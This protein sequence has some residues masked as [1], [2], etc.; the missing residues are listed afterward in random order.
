[1]NSDRPIV[2]Q[3]RGQWYTDGALPTPDPAAVIL[4]APTREYPAAISGHLREFGLPCQVW[5]DKNGLGAATATYSAIVSAASQYPDR[6]ILF[7]EDDISFHPRFGAIV[8]AT[9][10]PWNVGVV[11]F[12]DMREMPTG[13]PDGLYTL[14]ALGCD[15][16]GWWGNQCILIHR[17][18]AQWLITRSFFEAHIEESRGVRAHRAAYEDGG[19]NCS[20]IRLSLL[21][22]Q[23]PIR[24]R[25]AVHVPSLALHIGQRSICFPDRS[26]TLGERETRNY[27]SEDWSPR[28]NSSS[29]IARGKGDVR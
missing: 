21:V 14:S 15:G 4:Q 16:R 10:I 26:P 3:E 6:H 1:M 24:R 9:Q 5:H 12:C 22:D 25:Y 20:D 13:S 28:A 17:D 2:N 23:H 7:C 29:V 19:K 27:A 8:R 18:V 11:S